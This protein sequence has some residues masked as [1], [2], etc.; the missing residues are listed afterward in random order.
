MGQFVCRVCGHN[1][2]RK[3]VDREFHCIN[4]G[5]MF[6]D[7]EMFS[8]PSVKVKFLHPE[9]QLPSRA[10][11]GSV[12][13][14]IYAVEDIELYPGEQKLIPSG[15]AVELPP[16]TEMQIRGRSGLRVKRIGT[17][18]TG[19]IDPS[20]RGEVKVILENKSQ[21]RYLIKKGDRIAQALIVVKLP[22]T[23]ERVD[24]LSDTSRGAGGFGSSGK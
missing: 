8:V 22:Y 13:Y 4:C 16:H 5:T 12:G 24:E 15:W 23:F 17:S 14:D 9:A 6:V 3:D 7:P 2:Y 19:T 11:E 1:E 18:G 20:Y 10:D 21:D